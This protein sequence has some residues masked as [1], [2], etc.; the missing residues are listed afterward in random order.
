MDGKSFLF[1]TLQKSASQDFVPGFGDVRYRALTECFTS[2]SNDHESLKAEYSQLLQVHEDVC[3]QIKLLKKAVLLLQ[4]VLLENKSDVSPVAMD[5]VAQLAIQPMTADEATLL[6]SRL[7]HSEETRK[8]MKDELSK[9]RHDCLRRQ[10]AEAGLQQLVEEQ[11]NVIMKIE[12][13][14]MKVNLTNQ[15]LEN[16]KSELEKRLNDRDCQVAELTK[17]LSN[18]NQELSQL[19]QKLEFRQQDRHSMSSNVKEPT[20]RLSLTDTAEYTDGLHHFAGRSCGKAGVNRAVDL[21]STPSTSHSSTKLIYFYGHTNSPRMSTINK[22]SNEVTLS[23]V[24]SV[25]ACHG[26][27]RYIFQSSD[28]HS[29]VTRREIKDRSAIVPCCNGTV[30]VWIED[31]VY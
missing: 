24:Q 5:S 22:C 7:L 31:V 21:N 3:L 20:S 6:C 25:V 27:C 12:A 8:D 16:T 11:Q 18:R 17:E 30:T 1:N 10:G 15:S 28:S 4:Q 9:M 19:K 26:K 13:E 23:D 14:L 2:L 29:G